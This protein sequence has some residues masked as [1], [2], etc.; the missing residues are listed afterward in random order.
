M[1]IRCS[2]CQ[3]HGIHRLLI[4]QAPKPISN[5]LHRD[6]GTPS[7]SA[8]S[9]CVLTIMLRLR[10][11]I[12]SVAVHP[13]EC[14]SLCANKV[15]HSASPHRTNPSCWGWRFRKSTITPVEQGHPESLPHREVLPTALPEESYFI[16]G[17]MYFLRA[18]PKSV[19][20]CPPHQGWSRGVEWWLQVVY[21]LLTG[22]R[23]G[24]TDLRG[25]P[26]GR[27]RA[28]RASPNQVTAGGGR[29]IAQTR[30]FS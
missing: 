15:R 10:S 24:F 5:L 4:A 26:G 11:C 28:R 9:P 18:P 13:H 30:A 6:T 16:L 29:G 3:T 8:L 27:G 22:V 17:L 2:S 14:V 25:K 12:V 19:P 23:Y 20:V 1:P 21:R 7:P